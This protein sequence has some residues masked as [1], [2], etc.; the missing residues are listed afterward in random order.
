[1]KKFGKILLCFVLVLVIIF[2]FC[3][4]YSAF[5]INKPANVYYTKALPGKIMA[6]T[7]PPFGIFIEQRYISEGS[8]SGTILAHERIHWLQYQERGLFKFYYEYF[9]GLIKHGRLY[10]DLEKD[11]RKRSSIEESTSTKIYS[12][13]GFSIE[14]PIG[15]TPVEQESEGGPSVSINLGENNSMYYTSRYSWWEKYE[16]PAWKYIKEEK[17]GENIFK[18]Y[19]SNNGYIIYLLKNGDEGYRYS[20]DKNQLATFKLT[21]KIIK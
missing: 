19:D 4:V 16:I 1:M 11:A 8:E 9:G 10:N 14:I 12:G 6:M 13:H 7:I 18:V 5:K 3:G 20:G 2:S 15:Y 17:I 21:E